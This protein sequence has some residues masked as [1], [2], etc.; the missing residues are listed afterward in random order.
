MRMC[1]KK[2]MVNLGVG[3]PRVFKSDRLSASDELGVEDDELARYEINKWY[4]KRQNNKTSQGK[5][6]KTVKKKM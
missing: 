4:K 1:N 5:E 6:K 3:I 2:N